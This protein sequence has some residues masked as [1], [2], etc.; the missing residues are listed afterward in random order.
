MPLQNLKRF[1][2]LHYGAGYHRNGCPL[3]YGLSDDNIEIRLDYFVAADSVNYMVK[4]DLYGKPNV[5]I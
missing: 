1:W 2:K 3:C 5:Y 4:R